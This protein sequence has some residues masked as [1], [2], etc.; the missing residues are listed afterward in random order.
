MR[1]LGSVARTMAANKMSP[2]VMLAISSGVLLLVYTVVAKSCMSCLMR[3]KEGGR[4]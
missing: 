3:C 2:R 4:A 1:L